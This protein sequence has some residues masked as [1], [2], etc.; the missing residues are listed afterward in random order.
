MADFVGGCQVISSGFEL[1]EGDCRGGG[2]FVAFGASAGN[3]FG[4]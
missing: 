1:F 2:A 3:G 4:R